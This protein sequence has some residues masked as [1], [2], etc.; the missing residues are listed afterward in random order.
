MAAFDILNVQ[1]HEI[2]E[3]SKVLGALI[4]DRELCDT[5]IVT[6]LFRQYIGKVLEH[7]ELNAKSIYTVLLASPDA[8]V[9]SQVKRFME[10]EREIKKIF[11]DYVARYCK[12]G[13]LIKDHQK[14]LA[15]TEH[16]FRLVLARM[17][18]EFEELYPLVRRVS[19]NQQAKAA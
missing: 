13:L 14:F 12:N 10:G 3:L 16:M 1:N 7:I 5:D 18:A 15:E 2:Q 8:P 6:S 9:Q 4:K 17:Q 11:N 19:H